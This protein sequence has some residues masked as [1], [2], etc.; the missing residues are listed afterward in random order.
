MLTLTPC[1][2][3]RLAL[4]EE[5]AESRHGDGHRREGRRGGRGAGRG[6]WGGRVGRGGHADQRRGDDN[7]GRGRREDLGLQLPCSH[8][9]WTG[10][11]STDR[12][13]EKA[14]ARS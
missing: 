6:R 12:G 11:R 5:E 14:A 13:A 4:V 7:G 10:W 9:L 8:I 3:D 1:W 2:P